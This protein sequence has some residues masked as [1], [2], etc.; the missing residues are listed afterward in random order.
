MKRIVLLLALSALNVISSAARPA[1]R[2]AAVEA[3]IAA[4]PSMRGAVV[5]VMAVSASGD[6][7]VNIDC[8]RRLLP[9]SNMKLVST[10]AALHHFGA[11]WRFRTSIGID[12]EVREGVPRLSL[13]YFSSQSF[14]VLEIFFASQ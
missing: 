12:G 14:Q 13:L 6:T 7:L 3:V 4:S 8:E 5:S 9:A 11:D 1:A 10:G 2:N